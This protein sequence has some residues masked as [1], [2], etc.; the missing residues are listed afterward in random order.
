M[1]SIRVEDAPILGLFNNFERELRKE[2]SSRLEEEL[3]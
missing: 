2:K 1:R 3:F